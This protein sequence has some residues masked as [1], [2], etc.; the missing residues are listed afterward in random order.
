[1]SAPTIYRHVHEGRI[2]HARVGG[3]IRIPR[4]V[5]EAFERCEDVNLA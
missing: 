1:M 3:T 2:K 4:E 5:L